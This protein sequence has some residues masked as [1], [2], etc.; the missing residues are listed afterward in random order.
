V[1]YAGSIVTTTGAFPDLVV[2]TP[3]RDPV[4]LA[5]TFQGTFLA[6]NALLT[7]ASCVQPHV[8]AFFA[9][10]VAVAPGSKVQYRA[11][12]ALLVAAPPLGA[13]MRSASRRPPAQSDRPRAP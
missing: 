6:P 8:G 12:S 10:D 5:S 1:T 7:L 3:S 4:V 11:P 13:L 2:A 9:K